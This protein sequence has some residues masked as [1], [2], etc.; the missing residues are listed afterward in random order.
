MARKYC[1]NLLAVQDAW[2]DP[3]AWENTETISCR[4]PQSFRRRALSSGTAQL[5]LALQQRATTVP[6]D[7]IGPQAATVVRRPPLPVIRRAQVVTRTAYGRG[8]RVV[9]C[10]RTLPT[11]PWMRPWK[12]QLTVENLRDTL[13]PLSA[14]WTVTRRCGTVV[15]P[16]GP[17]KPPY[18]LRY[19][20]ES[21]RSTRSKV[22]TITLR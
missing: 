8:I 11:N 5:Q 19:S 4:G 9:Y 10:F 15:H 17:I 21:R 20:V 3:S 12:L 13:P 18:L 1:A 22:A 2:N 7:A 16:V 14:A 6:S